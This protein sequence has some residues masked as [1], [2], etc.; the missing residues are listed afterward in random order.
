L[1]IEQ[2]KIFKKIKKKNE[3]CLIPFTPG[4]H[5]PVSPSIQLRA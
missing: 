1:F 5:P 2:I 4:C 3:G